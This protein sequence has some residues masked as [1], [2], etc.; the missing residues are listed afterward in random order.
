MAENKPERMNR[1][2]FNVESL[3]VKKGS[4]KCD[5]WGIENQDEKMS[6]GLY[7]PEVFSRSWR[8]EWE[9]TGS[10]VKTGMGGGDKKIISERPS[11][12]T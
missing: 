2:F 5:D 7:G 12:T 10:K 9:T 4:G 11:C 8:W 3:R 1:K 6:E